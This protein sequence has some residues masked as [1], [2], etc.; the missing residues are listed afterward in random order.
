MRLALPSSVQRREREEFL[1]AVR[2]HGVL[3][4]FDEQPYL[5]QVRVCAARFVVGAWVPE[6]GRV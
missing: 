4:G 1:T 6:H 2:S 3:R 5:L